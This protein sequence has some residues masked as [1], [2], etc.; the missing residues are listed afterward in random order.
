MEDWGQR[1]GSY[2][3]V[4]R[5]GMPAKEKTFWLADLVQEE[6]EWH[7]WISKAAEVHAE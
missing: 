3:V 2:D 5:A 7:M 1:I 4:G 6:D